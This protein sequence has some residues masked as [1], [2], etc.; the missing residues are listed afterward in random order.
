LSCI[1]VVRTYDEELSYIKQLTPWKYQINP[2]FVPNMKVPGIFY[3][4][5]KLK[6]LVFEELKHHSES[7]GYGGF[8]PAVKQIANVA[9]LPGIV[10]A[11]VGKYTIL[12]TKLIII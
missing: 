8:L 3:V 11:S 5:D 1:I 4:N 2:G 9:A 10:K 12:N 7:G 6:D